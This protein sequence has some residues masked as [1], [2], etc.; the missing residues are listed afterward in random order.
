MPTGV[1]IRTKEYRDKMSKA[2]KGHIVSEQTRKKISL[3]NKG[4]KPK[5]WTVEASV[6]S[7]KG[8]HLTDE[9]KKKIGRSEENSGT[10]KGSE[11]G[12]HAMHLWVKKWKGTPDTCE[13]CGKTYKSKQIHWA[14]IDHK[15]RRILDDYIRLCAKCHREYDDYTF[16]K[17]TPW[18]KNKTLNGLS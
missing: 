8:K 14:N 6:K 12:Y 4:T 17:R 15:Y 5:S 11:A 10:W 9:H 2:G 3:S 7:R 1:Y 16:G 13:K 18:N